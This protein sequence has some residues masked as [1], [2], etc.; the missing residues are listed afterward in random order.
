[1]EQRSS[2]FGCGKFFPS[3][4]KCGSCHWA[5]YHDVQCQKAHWPSHKALCKRIA[6]VGKDRIHEVV[7]LV[8]V[9]ATGNGFDLFENVNSHLVLELKRRARVFYAATNELIFDLFNLHQERTSENWRISSVLLVDSG[10]VRKRK[11]EDK[12]RSTLRDFV[13]NDGGTVI[14]CG[15]IHIF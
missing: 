9:V 7:P 4:K 11:I 13:K 14:L 12:V 8:L 5:A 1:M 15:N 2:C 3:L 10:P 6:A